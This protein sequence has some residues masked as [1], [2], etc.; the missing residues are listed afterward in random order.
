MKI[1]RRETLVINGRLDVQR[2]RCGNKSLFAAGLSM[3]SVNTESSYRER[4]PSLF[5]SHMYHEYSMTDCNYQHQLYV[6]LAKIENTA[7]TPERPS[8]AYEALQWEARL[9][10]MANLTFGVR[11]GFGAQGGRAPTYS[12]ILEVMNNKPFTASLE[13]AQG[14]IRDASAWFKT[15]LTEARGLTKGM[16]PSKTVEAYEEKVSH[17]D[18]SIMY[19]SH[20][21]TVATLPVLNRKYTLQHLP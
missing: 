17:Q 18:E 4:F 5:I 10:P 3:V 6:L 1:N 11:G 9:R 14:Y 15:L 12:E 21:K 7:R 19:A 13:T 16:G 8:Y 2:C 20:V